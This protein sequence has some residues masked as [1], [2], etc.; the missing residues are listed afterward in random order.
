[1]AKLPLPKGY[2][3]DFQNPRVKPVGDV[4]I[5]YDNDIAK[6]LIYYFDGGNF[7]ELQESN[8][9]LQVVRNRT[10]GAKSSEG[11]TERIDFGDTDFFRNQ[12]F[13]TIMRFTVPN[14]DI[15]STFFFNVDS[16]FVL[17][18]NVESLSRL[19]FSWYTGVFTELDF[20][21]IT[22]ESIHT[23]VF[24]KLQGAAA[25]AYLY[26]DGTKTKL[27]SGSTGDIVYASGRGASLGSR[28]WLPSSQG[29]N[30]IIHDFAYSN[31]ALSEEEI[32]RY[33]ANPYQILKPKTQPVYF[34]AG[35]A[36][37]SIT[38]TNYYKLL[39]AGAA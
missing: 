26:V 33:A 4:E 25:N 23:I 6:D 17:G 3:P 24:S 15:F 7:A 20:G 8:T 21:A 39:L 11:T 29:E 30:L 31:K 37:P 5:D 9:T 22:S 16:R 12:T 38:P 27:T 2:S 28:S 13:T 18:N 36:A 35:G 14:P 34:T 32:D 10:L 1:M 19:G